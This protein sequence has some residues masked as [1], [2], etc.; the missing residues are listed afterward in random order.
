VISSVPLARAIAGKLKGSE[1]ETP[2][3]SAT[4]GQPGATPE[5]PSTNYPPGATIP[6]GDMLNAVPSG[7]QFSDNIDSNMFTPQESAFY[8]KDPYGPL[9]QEDADAADGIINK[10]LG[11][12]DIKAANGKTYINL[13]SDDDIKNFQ[14]VLSDSVERNQPIEPE[15]AQELFASSDTFNRILS[16]GKTLP[17]LN[18]LVSHLQGVQDIVDSAIDKIGAVRSE[19]FLNIIKNYAGWSDSKFQQFA[20]KV[21]GKSGTAFM[22]R[23]IGEGAIEDLEKQFENGPTGLSNRALSH[24]NELRE[25][26]QY[27]LNRNSIPKAIDTI[28]KLNSIANSEP[29]KLNQMRK[30]YYLMRM[31]WQRAASYDAAPAI[32]KETLTGE[33]LGISKNPEEK[34]TLKPDQIVSEK[35]IEAKENPDQN[36][37]NPE[38][39]VE[40]S[41][42][43]PT[44]EPLKEVLAKMKEFKEKAPIFKKLIQ[45]IQDEGGL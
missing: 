44:K 6:S 29:F 21:K 45:C 1:V 14:G 30:S 19:K 9:T 25:L 20:S 43:N 26:R 23:V 24:L 40:M 16:D 22:N 4:Q 31:M 5:A 2:G 13:L 41:E 27:Y 36:G 7:P 11:S 35:P 3:P 28:G 37:E 15:L 42:D 33:N 10:I 34:Y 38:E 8:E 12:G 39:K 18:N 32:D 17:A